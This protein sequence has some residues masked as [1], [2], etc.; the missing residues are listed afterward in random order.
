MTMVEQLTLYQAALLAYAGCGLA[1]A[2]YTYSQMRDPRV[3]EGLRRLAGLDNIRWFV[4]LL[5]AVQGLAWPVSLALSSI[6]ASRS[7]KRGGPSPAWPLDVAL[8]QTLNTKLGEALTEATNEC[9]DD[10]AA[11]ATSLTVLGEYAGGA[12]AMSLEDEHSDVHGLSNELI[13]A[14][15]SGVGNVLQRHMQD[16]DAVKCKFE[17]ESQKIMDRLHAGRWPD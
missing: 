11:S 8:A 3:R 9:D 14:L 5:A 16:C 17:R 13:D 6:G 10:V 1:W 12:F 4:P 2:V 7:P 15:A